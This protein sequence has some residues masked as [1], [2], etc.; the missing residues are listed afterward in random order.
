MV[1]F[2]NTQS[3]IWDI[4]ISHKYKEQNRGSTIA[5][6]KNINSNIHVLSIC[7]EGFHI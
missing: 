6:R 1:F 5:E 2:K 4:Y 3:D 7:C